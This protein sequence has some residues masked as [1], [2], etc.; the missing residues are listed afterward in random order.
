MLRT[1]DGE[2]SLLKIPVLSDPCP[3]TPV[4]N[5]PV[6]NTPVLKAEPEAKSDGAAKPFTVEF[7]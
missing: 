6:R 2:V 4:P 7:V 1:T 5:A 3:T